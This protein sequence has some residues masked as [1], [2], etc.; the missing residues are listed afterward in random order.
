[1]PFTAEELVAEAR[2]EVGYRRRVYPR[3]VDAG[4]IDKAKADRQ[5]QLME[6]IVAALETQAGK[7]R[8]L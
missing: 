3:W 1:M 6:A 4:K 5:L 7:E 8:L 2:R